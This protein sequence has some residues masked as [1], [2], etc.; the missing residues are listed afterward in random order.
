MHVAGIILVFIWDTWAT[1]E[2]C[3]SDGVQYIFFTIPRYQFSQPS[4]E[5]E[6]N[7]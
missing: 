3:I 7:F 6:T 2:Y 1:Y 4:G 5:F